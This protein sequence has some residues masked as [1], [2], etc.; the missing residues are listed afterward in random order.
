[1]DRF[2]FSAIVHHDL[3]QLLVAE[4]DK[5]RN[6]FQ[7]TA[8]LHYNGNFFL[9]VFNS[10]LLI[11]LL[12]R[13]DMYCWGYYYFYDGNL[14]YRHYADEGAAIQKRFRKLYERAENHD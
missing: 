12:P 10:I 7:A 13:R 1:M 3:T 8:S 5:Y 2:D 11:S 6:I 14:L 4:W 9:N